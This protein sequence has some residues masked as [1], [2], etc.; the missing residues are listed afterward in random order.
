MH[1]AKIWLRRW[2]PSIIMMVLIFTASGTSGSDLPEFGIWD[3]LV[4]KGGHI[5]GYALLAVSYLHGLAHARSINR[6]DLFLAILLAGLYAATDEFHQSFTPGRTPSPIDAGI[7][8][9]GAVLGAGIW[10]WLR[11]LPTA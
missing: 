6:R 3:L 2:G 8:T 5:L 4:K 9:I 7:D 10:T 1:D 11:S